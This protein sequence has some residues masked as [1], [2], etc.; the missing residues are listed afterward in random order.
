MTDT[1]R[2][3]VRTYLVL[4]VLTTLAASFIWGVNTLFLL[5]A[6]LDNTQAFAANAFYTLGMVLFEIPT[7]VV[8]DTRGRRFSFLLG[9]LSLLASTVLYWVMWQTR[10]PFWGWAI[11][12]VLIGLGF[13]FFSGATEAWLVDALAAARYTGELE[14]VFGRSQVAAGVAMLGGSVLGGVVA[15]FT[16]LGMPY[17]LRAG[18]LLVTAV[19]AWRWMHD[20]GFSPD[21]TIRPLA[22]VRA[23]LAGAVEGG[24]RNRP[25]RWLMIAAPF[26]AG[27]GVYIF[28]AL[29]PYLLQLWGDPNAY[30]I[31][32]LAA[33]LVAGAQV[34]GGLL[35][36]QVRHLFRRRT[37]A[38][39]I[40][41]I[42][43]VGL[44]VAIGLSGGFWLAIALVAVWSMLSA[45]VAP[46]RQSFING[47]IPSAQRATVLSFD[48]LMGS[49]GGVVVQPALGRVA[50]VAGYPASYLVSAGIQAVALPFVLLARREHAP[51][52]PIT[53]E[54]GEPA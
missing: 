15:Q 7:G 40:G 32:G 42:V 41:G 4:T 53:A 24:L 25:V 39:L 16:D 18:L 20:L 35:V 44:L 6:G 14:A 49:A 12:S 52:D 2:R 47:V 8:A 17:L 29:Q 21:R 45:M 9:T 38:L 26:T 23:V 11:A 5:D 43:G 30:S 46:L 37:D 33:A 48:S 50:D 36:S 13:T 51:S 1:A 10:A 28:Y 22:A 34:V 19:V 31:A 3:V 27:T 54:T